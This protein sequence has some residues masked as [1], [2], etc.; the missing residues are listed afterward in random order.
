MIDIN[1]EKM[2]EDHIP[3]WKTWITVP[4]VREVWFIDG[5]ETS[6]YIFDKL[7]GNGHTFPF[8]IYLS[9]L[10]IGYIQYCDLYAYRTLT[11]KPKGLFINENPGTFC[12]DLFIAESDFLNKG[13]GTEIIKQFTQKLIDELD[14][15]KILIDPAST[16]KRAIRCYE[17]AGFSFVRNANDGI[18]E[19]VVMQFTPGEN[20]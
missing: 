7:K 8:I 2:T 9:N 11:P 12:I 17:K 20:Q 4:H 5:Y 18:T 6:D 14:A 10:P 1:F 16:N 13:Y 3:L 19:C 15:K